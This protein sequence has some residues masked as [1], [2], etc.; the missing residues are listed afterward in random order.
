MELVLWRHAEAEDGIP[1]MKRALTDKGRRQA[2][3][4]AK[5][6]RPRLEGQWEILVSPATRTR[7]TADALGLDYDVRIPLGTSA[8]EEALLREAG[9]PGNGKNVMIVG[10]QP[11]L[12]RVAARLLTGQAGEL[13]IRKGALCWFSGKPGRL[14]EVNGT[15]LRAVIGPDFAG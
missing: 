4:V 15:L 8:T 7:Q 9:W 11:T 5:W 13:T 12:G 2:A 1:D 14:A 3:R 10:H 6:L